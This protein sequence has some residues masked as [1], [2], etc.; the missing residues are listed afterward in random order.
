MGAE[1]RVV[2]NSPTTENCNL[3][4][5]GRMPVRFAGF[6]FRCLFALSAA[7]F[8]GDNGKPLAVNVDG[9][10]GGPPKPLLPGWGFFSPPRHRQLISFTDDGR[11]DQRQHQLLH[12]YGGFGKF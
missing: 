5:A 1:S 7:P 3:K 8:N 4:L 11:H 10:E 2:G 9:A 6:R 12:A